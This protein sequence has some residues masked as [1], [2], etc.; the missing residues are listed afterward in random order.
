MVAFA[1][2]ASAAASDRLRHDQA[3]MIGARAPRS[4]SA[5]G[6][7]DSDPQVPARTYLS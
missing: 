6:A 3:V 4:S 7:D 2:I 1:P 5:S